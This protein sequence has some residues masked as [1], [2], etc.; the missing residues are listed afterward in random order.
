MSGLLLLLRLLKVVG[1]FVAVKVVILVVGNVV[2]V[3]IFVVNVV[4]V[5]FVFPPTR[6]PNPPISSPPLRSV[7]PFCVLLQEGHAGHRSV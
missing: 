3:V 4:S 7:H 6:S 1:V 2:V 5:F